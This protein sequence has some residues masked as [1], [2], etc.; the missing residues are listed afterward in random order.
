MYLALYPSPMSLN[1]YS[2]KHDNESKF[3]KEKNFWPSF[4]KIK[5]PWFY[6]RLYNIFVI[7]GILLF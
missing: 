3:G 2:S 6:L 4:S 5:D 7:L 1:Y